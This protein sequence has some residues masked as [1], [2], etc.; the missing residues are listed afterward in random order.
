M[1]FSSGPSK[2]ASAGGLTRP[3]GKV[4]GKRMESRIPVNA[5]A[6]LASQE[7]RGVDGSD[8]EDEGEP[9]LASQNGGRAASGAVLWKVQ[10]FTAL[11]HVK[12][13]QFLLTLSPDCLGW[14][15][16]IAFPPRHHMSNAVAL[17][18]GRVE[19]REG[20][21]MLGYQ[22]CRKYGAHLQAPPVG[23]S[24]RA[25]D[26]LPKPGR[27]SGRGRMSNLGRGTKRK[28]DEA[29]LDPLIGRTVRKKIQQQVFKVS[30]S[31]GMPQ[32]C[33]LYH[34]LRYTWIKNVTP[35]P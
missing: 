9:P 34:V 25:G 7:Y 15:S 8:G 29:G 27:A 23:R 4:E 28:P 2:V 24:K 22:Q 33:L 11:Q 12:C 19:K 3:S 32:P 31:G 6:P 26:A 35:Q 13:V 21:R 10:T 5:S 16:G 17:K 1:S 14:P 30:E 20:I 18:A